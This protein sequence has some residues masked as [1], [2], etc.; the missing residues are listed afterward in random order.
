MLILKCTGQWLL[1]NDP[2]LR[3]TIFS[4]DNDDVATTWG[5][6]MWM[7]NMGWEADVNNTWKMWITEEIQAGGWFTNFTN[8]VNL[9][10]VHSAGHEVPRT[11]PSRALQAF[12]RYL[13]GEF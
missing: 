4:G 3:L 13:N 9:L 1:D 6:Q 7:W 10:T 5:T 8:G 2:S 11:Q 12:T